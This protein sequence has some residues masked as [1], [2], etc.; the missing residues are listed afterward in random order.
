MK[1]FY[2]IFLLAIV[3][4]FLST[5]SSNK[6]EVNLENNG[7]FFKI[8]KIIISNNLLIN[9]DDILTKLNQ[10]YGKNIFL[11]KREDIEESLENISF[12]KKIEVKKKYPDTIMI[13]IFE[14]K[15]LGILF[16]DKTK[17]LLD[18]TSNLIE[19]DKK[20]NFVELP[21]IIGDDAEK[22][23]INFL[24]K[25]KN[26]EFPTNNIKNF[27]YFKIE[28]WDLELLD[29]RKIK[30]PYNVSN[31][32]IRK[33]IELLNRKDFQSYKIIDLRVEGKIIVE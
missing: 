28:R 27:Y 5:Y 25:L 16:K 12:L 15:P 20:M 31:R 4:V 10:L 13:K 3:F 11:I 29:N 14:T 7:T 8:Q 2:R 32:K 19:I 18:S 33:S 24:D 9:K 1:R 30:F 22:N 17:Y 21:N 23:F 26:N 6:F